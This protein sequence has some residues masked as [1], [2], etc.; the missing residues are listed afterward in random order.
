MA[1]RDGR[2]LVGHEDPREVWR[3]LVRHGEH[4]LM[5]RVLREGESSETVGPW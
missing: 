3:W 2:V 4:G 1:V 5:L